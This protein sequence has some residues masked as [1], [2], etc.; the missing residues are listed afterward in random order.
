MDVT[1]VK[2]ILETNCDV[3]KSLSTKADKLDCIVS[4][5]EQ[6]F[7]QVSLSDALTGPITNLT[8]I[9]DNIEAQKLIG[10]IKQM[11]EISGKVI[12]K[13]FSE[14]QDYEEIINVIQ[15]LVD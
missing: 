2:K 12:V 13:G 6:S 15:E 8:A 11:K 3:V 10:Y 9:M 5:F 1:K 4:L 14:S 7:P